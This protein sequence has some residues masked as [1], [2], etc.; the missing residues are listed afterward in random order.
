MAEAYLNK[1]G[2]DLFFAESAGLEPGKLNPLIVDVMKEEGIDISNKKTNDVFE[3][4][5][6]GKFYSYVIAV[7]DKEAA[8]RCPIFPG[9]G[10]VTGALRIRPSLKAL[11]NQLKKNLN[12]EFLLPI[13]IK[14]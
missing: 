2:G 3:F 9:I 4:Y 12:G 14:D 8:E 6:K 5:K 1:F 11:T 10:E 7:C 13:I